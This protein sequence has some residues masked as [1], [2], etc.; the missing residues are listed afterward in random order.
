LTDRPDI[1][2][3]P[4]LAAALL[5]LQFAVAALVP[6][7]DAAVEA[8]AGNGTEHIEAQSGV[9]CPPGHDHLDCMFCRFAGHNLVSGAAASMATVQTV[10]TFVQAS[11]GPTHTGSPLFSGPLGPRAPPIA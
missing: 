11:T 8:A 9:P 5:V 7:A 3:R 4:L 1:R 6:L 10:W 2:K